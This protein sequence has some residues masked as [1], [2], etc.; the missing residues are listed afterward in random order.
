[1]LV[2]STSG[3]VQLRSLW[4]IM[5]SQLLLAVRGMPLPLGVALLE[6]TSP[7]PTNLVASKLS[8]STR[9][10]S[11]ND[12]DVVLFLELRRL[13]QGSLLVIW[14]KRARLVGVR[15][16][17]RGTTTLSVAA[18]V[19][20][21]TVGE[22]LVATGTGVVD[23]AVVGVAG[24]KGGGGVDAGVNAAVVGV[25][26]AGV[27]AAAVGVADA[28]LGGGMVDA[29]VKAAVVGVAEYSAGFP[30]A[31]LGLCLLLLGAGV[32]TGE[33]SFS[34]SREYTHNH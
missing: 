11:S 26:D 14:L 33:K 17:E 3:S 15:L 7:V 23:T 2:S 27:N 6:V 30:G 5:S 4:G 12:V 1:M 16:R 10:Y 9:R 21:Y 28:E 19:L 8:E 31:S 29:G 25:V 20:L 32:G 24:A 18:A 34:I 22:P 13:N